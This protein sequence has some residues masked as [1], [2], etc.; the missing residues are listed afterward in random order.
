MSELASEPCHSAIAK[1]RPSAGRE[2][3][4][5]PHVVV[6]G[7]LAVNV[8]VT[9]SAAPAGDAVDAGLLAARLTGAG[10]EAALRAGCAAG[11][12]AVSRCGGRPGRRT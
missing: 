2:C 9:P 1:R 5:R 10:P 6:V 8:L 4:E 7:D 3:G 11:A 12:E